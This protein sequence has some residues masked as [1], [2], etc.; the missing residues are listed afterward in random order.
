MEYKWERT[1]PFLEI[2][3]FT[4]N[5]LFEDILE[6][7][8][9]IDL[10]PV[11]SG[12][13]TTNYIIKTNN[14]KKKYILKIFFQQEQ[15]YKK[16][17]EL[18]KKLRNEFIS[19]PKLYKFG[20]HKV[21]ENREYAI[22][23]YIEG[24]TIGHAIQEGYRLEENFIIQVAK[25]LAKIHSYKFDNIGFLDN[26]LNVIEEMPPLVSWYENFMGDMAKKRLGKTVVE[27]IDIAIKNNEK[28][29]TQLDSDARLV[30]GDFQGT[31]IIIENGKLAG[32]LDWE[33]AMA[34]HPLGDIGQF[35]RYEEYFSKNL[36]QIFE[37]EY[38]KVSDYKLAGNWLQISKLRDLVNLI[39][40]I[41][42]Q[43]EMPIKHKNIKKIIVNTLNKL[44]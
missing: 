40:L 39:Q 12:C 29:L 43:Q 36:V 3:D 9:I 18:L 25:S 26:N 22:Y 11:D 37:Y 27:K 15:N 35:F 32:I 42:T 7:E 8:T 34:G 28:I 33:F 4:V 14:C 19:V 31:N 17:I 13:R 6:E 16:E 10:R 21:I 1:F 20:R 24:K 38:N 41:D 5:K 44:D 23:Q 2:D 30:H